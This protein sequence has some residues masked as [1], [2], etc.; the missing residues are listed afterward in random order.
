[1]ATAIVKWQ[2]RGLA[3]MDRPLLLVALLLLVPLAGCAQPPSAAPAD[4][5]QQAQP[6]P[7][8]CPQP[9]PQPD[10]VHLKDSVDMLQGGGKDYAWKVG[11]GVR[12]LTVSVTAT[13]PQ[14]A[15]LE[16]S[17][18]LTYAL[19]GGPGR[20]VHDGGGSATYVQGSL[21]GGSACIVCFD[22]QDV[23]GGMAQLAG[24]WTFHLEWKAAVGHYDLQVTVAY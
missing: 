1:M 11:P 13:G 18:G 12:V 16:E 2:L 5:C 3:R 22:G 23:E 6:D 9:A 4:P 15:P 19:T 10:P 7:Q 8:A 20:T 24:D 14:G 17:A 21:G